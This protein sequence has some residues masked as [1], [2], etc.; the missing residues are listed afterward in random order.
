MSK[1]REDRLVRFILYGR[2]VY[3]Y[4]IMRVV[5]PH[6]SLHFRSC[7]GFYEDS[8]HEN[9]KGEHGPAFLVEPKGIEPSTS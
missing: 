4:F 9:R 8:H 3:G 5:D 1:D 2:L 7:L 6:D